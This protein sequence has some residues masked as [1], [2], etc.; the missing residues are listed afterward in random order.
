MAQNLGRVAFRNK[1]GSFSL[2]KRFCSAVNNPPMNVPLEDKHDVV[3]KRK[4]GDGSSASEVKITTLSNGIKVA[5]EDSFGQFC[6]IGGKWF[7]GLIST[8]LS[9]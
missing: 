9:S 1:H 3:R 6:T 7:L 8:E 5:S 4:P 2:L